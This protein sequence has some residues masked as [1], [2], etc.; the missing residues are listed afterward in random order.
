MTLHEL[1]IT[2]VAKVFLPPSYRLSRGEKFNRCLRLLCLRFDRSRCR[3]IRFF[4]RLKGRVRVRVKVRIR[5]PI[6][7]LELPCKSIQ[8]VFLL[9]SKSYSLL[10]CSGLKHV[11]K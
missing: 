2:I 1:F 4:S 9:L 11:K 3:I 5:A 7:G 6:R 8:C 10:E